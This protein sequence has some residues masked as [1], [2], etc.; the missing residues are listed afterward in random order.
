MVQAISRALKIVRLVSESENGLRL[1]EL[2]DIME[3]KRTTVY[4]LAATLV[5]EGMLVK[6]SDCSYQLGSLLEELA[7][8]QGQKSMKLNLEKKLLDLH[9]I[10]PESSIIY[11]EAKCNDI[12]VKIYIP[13]GVGAKVQNAVNMQINPYNT[14]CG[15]FYFGLLPDDILQEIKRKYPFEYWGMDYWKGTQFFK[16]I[17]QKSLKD[18]FSESPATPVDILKYGVPVFELGGALSGV[19][20]FTI[21]KNNIEQTQ[22]AKILNDLKAYSQQ[23]TE[24]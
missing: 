11:S 6:M 10:Y 18:G 20:T 12:R 2:A 9:K 3:L 22:I 19:I 4:N 23:I 24:G 16:K 7:S 5:K 1:Y 21:N 8:K 15:L 14:V 13:S 17:V